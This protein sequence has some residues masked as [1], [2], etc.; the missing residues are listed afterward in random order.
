MKALAI[1]FLGLVSSLAW[2]EERPKWLMELYPEELPNG[3]HV[4]MALSGGTSIA[5]IT[6]HTGI[7]VSYRGYEPE[8]PQIYR[9]AKTETGWSI[10]SC[11]W[12]ATGLRT[13][14]IQPGAS[15]RFILPQASETHRIF[16]LFFIDDTRKASLI[17]TATKG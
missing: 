6:N 3:V 16:T 9:Q 8:K 2:S 10:P 15:Q 1:L 14:S 12:C 13:F 4:E 5:K 7:T 11:H 17:A